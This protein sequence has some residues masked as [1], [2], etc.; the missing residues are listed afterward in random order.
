M[1]SI[2]TGGDFSCLVMTI[3]ILEPRLLQLSK[4]M[5]FQFNTHCSLIYWISLSH[6]LIDLPSKVNFSCTCVRKIILF[7]ERNFPQ[8]SSTKVCWK[9]GDTSFGL[10]EW[11]FMITSESRRQ[12]SWDSHCNHRLPCQIYCLSFYLHST[13]VYHGIIIMFVINHCCIYRY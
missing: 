9:H 5:T 10:G 7:S 3:G 11:G 2:C 1:C 6:H 8:L 4:I 12:S 13:I